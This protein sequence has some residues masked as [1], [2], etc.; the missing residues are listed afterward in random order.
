MWLSPSGPGSHKSLDLLSSWLE[1]S[2]EKKCRYAITTQRLT[3]YHSPA[4]SLLLTI[5]LTIVLLA[6]LLTTHLH[7]SLVGPSSLSHL[8]LLTPL[9]NPHC[10]TI[11]LTIYLLPHS[12]RRQAGSRKFTHIPDNI[13]SKMISGAQVGFDALYE[14]IAVGGDALSGLAYSG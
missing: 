2:K 11:S 14:S 6:A 5:L 13:L 4:C 7:P 3:H 1:R 12:L 8:P 9:A 10:L